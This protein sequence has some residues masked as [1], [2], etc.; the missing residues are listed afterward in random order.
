MVD[1]TRRGFLRTASISAAAMGVLGALPS[2]AHADEHGTGPA[3]PAPAASGLVPVTVPTGGAPALSAP[4]V[5][6]IDNPSSGKGV[7][8]IGEQGITFDNPALVQSLQS[9][10]A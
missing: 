3:A 1:L 4:L 8:F 6:Y 5:V 9:A 10:M 2:L 7:I